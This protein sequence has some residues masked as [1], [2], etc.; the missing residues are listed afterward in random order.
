MS[1]SAP[2]TKRRPN[3][4]PFLRVWKV[5]E[6]LSPLTLVLTYHNEQVWFWTLMIRD[7]GER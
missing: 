4:D 1:P 2:E 6:F 7:I 5:L 3:L